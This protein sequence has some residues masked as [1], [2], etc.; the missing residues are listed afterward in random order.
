MFAAV[1]LTV[2]GSLGDIDMIVAYFTTDFML[3]PVYILYSL[4]LLLPS[5]YVKVLALLFV[6]VCT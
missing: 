5:F 4:G 3:Q 6:P 1:P 2:L